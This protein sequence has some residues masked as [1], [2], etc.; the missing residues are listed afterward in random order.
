MGPGRPDGSAGDQ[1]GVQQPPGRRRRV[2][3][4]GQGV[5]Q[6]EDPP[7]IFMFYRI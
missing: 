3:Q 4:R 2:G 7:V 1:H 6:P 5:V